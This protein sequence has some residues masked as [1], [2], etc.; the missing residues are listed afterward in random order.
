MLTSTHLFLM[1]ATQ[2]MLDAAA[3]EDWRELSSLL[4]GVSFADE[5]NRFPEALAWQRDY[6]LEHPEEFGWW[7]YFIIHGMDGRLAGTCGY[8]GTPSPEGEVEIG[9]EIA[10]RYEGKG[11]GT[12]AANALIHNAFR[13]PEVNTINAHTLPEENASVQVLRKLGFQFAGEEHSLED[14]TVWAWRLEKSLPA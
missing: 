1:P 13:H 12:E 7:T 6:Q 4:G 9:Y 10:P 14:G 8:K 2:K 3:D 5:W 11:L